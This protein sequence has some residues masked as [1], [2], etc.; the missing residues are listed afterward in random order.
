MEFAS[1][2][3]VEAAQKGLL[4]AEVP[5]KAM[6]R[7]GGEPKLRTFRDGTRH[8]VLLLRRAFG[9]RPAPR[10]SATFSSMTPADELAQ[11]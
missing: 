2:M 8:L 6:P 7:A 3:I 11:S 5:V 4:L 1:E 9:T 10:M